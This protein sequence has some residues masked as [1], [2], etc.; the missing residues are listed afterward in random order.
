MKRFQ[1]YLIFFLIAMA[2]GLVL[3]CRDMKQKDLALQETTID[4]K[5]GIVSETYHFIQKKYLMEI[6]HLR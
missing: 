2:I 6:A 5:N 1:Y 4:K 3:F